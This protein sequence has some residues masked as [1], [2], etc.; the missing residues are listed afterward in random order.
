MAASAF[1][2]QPQLAQPKPIAG[3]NVAVSS[4]AADANSIFETFTENSF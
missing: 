2:E 1:K 3:I 4:A